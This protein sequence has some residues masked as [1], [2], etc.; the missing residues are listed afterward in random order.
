MGTHMLDQ[1]TDDSVRRKTATTTACVAGLGHCQP[2]NRR[3][4][5][6]SK[7]N[8]TGRANP[9][10]CS[11]L[12]ARGNQA[13]AAGRRRGKAPTSCSDT[14]VTAPLAASASHATRWTKRLSRSRSS[15][16]GGVRRPAPELGLG[17]GL[18]RDHRSP[19]TDVTFAQGDGQGSG[20]RSACRQMLVRQA[21]R[22][23]AACSW[24]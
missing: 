8:I 12:S 17:S 3:S 18:T 9:T 2:G 1:L 10:A 6:A 13:A 22:S 4:A 21:Q 5:A 24:W 11:S 15:H 19:A 23:A 20:K 7:I 16:V 14:A